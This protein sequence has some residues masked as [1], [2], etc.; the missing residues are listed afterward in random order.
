MSKHNNI[1]Y[2]IG[3]YKNNKFIETDPPCQSEEEAIHKVKILNLN[4]PDNSWLIFPK[5]NIEF[6]YKPSKVYTKE[7]Y[8]K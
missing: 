8:N 7:E 4:N 6:T 5:D 3:Y 2:K 1:I